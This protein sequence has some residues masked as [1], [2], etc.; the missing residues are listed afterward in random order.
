MKSLI[1]A[2]T[3]NGKLTRSDM[4]IISHSK[5]ISDDIHLITNMP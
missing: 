2:Y 4:E 1:F 5:V 3:I